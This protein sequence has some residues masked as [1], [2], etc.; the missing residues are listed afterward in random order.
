[1]G[2]AYPDFLVIHFDPIYEMP[3]VSFAATACLVPHG[4]THGGREA[5]K[6]FGRQQMGGKLTGA[7]RRT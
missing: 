2:P 3:E 6:V 7:F 5:T 1:M 4:V